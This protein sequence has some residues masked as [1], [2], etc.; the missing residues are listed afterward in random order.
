MALGDADRA[1]DWLEQGYRGRGIWLFAVKEGT[2]FDDF[3]HDLRF[4]DLLRRMN[5]PETAA[6]S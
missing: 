6:D 3:R 1:C 2:W 5:F 4:E